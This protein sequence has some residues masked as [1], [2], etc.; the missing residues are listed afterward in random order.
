[1]F[2]ICSESVQNFSESVQNFQ[3][4]S[5]SVQNFQQFSESVQN[6]QQFSEFRV[7]LDDMGLIEGTVLYYVVCF[8]ARVAL[9]GPH[10]LQS[11]EILNHQGL[12]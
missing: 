6:F 12:L 8:C 3:Q 9:G 10:T 2:R 5:E 1:M 7:A 11:E 4:F